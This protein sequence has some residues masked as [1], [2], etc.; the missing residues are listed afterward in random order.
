MQDTLPFMVLFC[1]SFVLIN[2]P[3]G[4]HGLIWPFILYDLLLSF[5]PPAGMAATP[6]TLS[7][8][9]VYIRDKEKGLSKVRGEK[10][11]S[12]CD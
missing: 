2:G 4:F 6:P 11:P 12:G 8:S 1:L 10:T 3:E 9:L 5:S 7:F